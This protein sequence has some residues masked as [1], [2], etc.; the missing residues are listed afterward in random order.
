MVKQIITMQNYLSDIMLPSLP[1]WIQDHEE[2]YFYRKEG[3]TDLAIP[4]DFIRVAKDRYEDACSLLK[5]LKNIYHIKVDYQTVFETFKAVNMLVANPLSEPVFEFKVKALYSVFKN[6]PAIIFNEKT[7]RRLA[8]V[9][10]VFPSAYEID[11]VLMEQKQLLEKKIAFLESVVERRKGKI[12][13]EAFDDSDEQQKEENIQFLIKLNQLK[14]KFAPI[15][16]LSERIRILVESY[17]PENAVNMDG[18]KLIE[19]LE[20]C[21]EKVMNE[22]IRN[23]LQ[24]KINII[25]STQTQIE[26]LRRLGMVSGPIRREA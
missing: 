9:T 11:K 25:R 10:P 5:E 23:I 14:A 13:N 2:V 17:I 8:V 18:F 20:E 3:I 6:V 19:K 24:D 12:D 1:E 7:C 16:Q 21:K 15:D 4:C 22:D 26:D